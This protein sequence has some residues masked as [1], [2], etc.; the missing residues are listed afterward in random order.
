VLAHGF[1]ASYAEAMHAGGHDG[2]WMTFLLTI[3]AVTAALG[4]VGMAQLRRLERLGRDRQRS[5][6]VVRD[7]D[8]LS[9]V[10]HVTRTWLTVAILALAVFVV[11]ENLEVIAQGR[12]A[13]FLD[14]IGGHHDAAIPAFMF[15]SFIAGVIGGLVAW[16]REIL[17]IRLATAVTAARDSAARRSTLRQEPRPRLLIDSNRLRGPPVLTRA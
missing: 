11:Q 17:R 7:G 6:T 10:R 4:L 3:A 8:V 12:P 14:A 13:P 9:L 2:Y 15:V 1:R 16:R 5:R